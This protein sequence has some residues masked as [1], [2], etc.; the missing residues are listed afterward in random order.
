MKDYMDKIYSGEILNADEDFTR[1]CFIVTKVIFDYGM[2]SESAEKYDLLAFSKMIAEFYI[3]EKSIEE[4]KLEYNTYRKAMETDKI[5]D[6]WETLKIIQN[7][8][9]LFDQKLITDAEIKKEAIYLDY[10]V[11]V[12]CEKF[13]E[14]KKSILK[15]K[16]TVQYFYS[17]IHLEEL[18]KR[19]DAIES[20]Q[21]MIDTLSEISD[22]YGFFNAN[23]RLTIFMEHPIYSYKRICIHGEM[24]NHGLEEYRLRVEK[25]KDI[26]HGNFRNEEHTKIIN[27]KDLLKDKEARYL[28]DMALRKYGSQIDSAEI[29]RVVEN[30]NILDE[31]NILNSY[32]YS[33]MNAMMYLSYK[34]DKKKTIRSG[35][36]D[37]E[38]LINAS[39]CKKFVTTDNKL[40]QR[41]KVVYNLL[42]LDV[43]VLS[44]EEFLN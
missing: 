34:A 24:V 10:N 12:D 15:M 29:E 26:N 23:N 13:E 14:I 33:I 20:H 40:A 27:T 7:S 41:A 32:I 4:I 18:Y 25:D 28:F 5:I 3:G 22:N 31:Y 17:T 1:D 30:I 2:I 44:L 36:Y 6:S 16:S 35:L 38:H 39:K 43:Q 37:V 8:P 9:D 21:S 19:D 11:M 42:K